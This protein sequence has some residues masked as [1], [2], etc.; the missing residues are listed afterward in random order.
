MS[1]E[2]DEASG[3]FSGCL[4]DTTDIIVYEL[5]SEFGVKDLTDKVRQVVHMFRKSPLKNDALQKSF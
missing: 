2:I 3:E 1:E 4:T 5:T